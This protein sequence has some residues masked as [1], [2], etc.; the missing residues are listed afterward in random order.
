MCPGSRMERFIFISRFQTEKFSAIHATSAKSFGSRHAA[1]AA[2][3]P[4][5]HISSPVASS[6]YKFP[7]P[8]PG[9]ERSAVAGGQSL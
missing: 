3:F 6:G 9:H 4:N 8:T 1:D 5:N 2:P 7:P